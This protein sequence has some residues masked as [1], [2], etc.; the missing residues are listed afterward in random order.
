MEPPIPYAAFPRPLE[1]RAS[2]E[3]ELEKCSDWSKLSVKTLRIACQAEFSEDLSHYKPCFRQLVKE[4]TNLPDHVRLRAVLLRIRHPLPK[5]TNDAREL[6]DLKER[7]LRAIGTD[8]PKRGWYTAHMTRKEMDGMDRC[9][10]IEKSRRRTT[11]N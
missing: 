9:N 1:L 4:I 5:R 3:A 6:R 7:V 8:Q 10:I 2:I 11:R